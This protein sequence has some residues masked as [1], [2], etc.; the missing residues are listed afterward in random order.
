ML[1]GIGQGLD[2]L[3]NK[4]K[5]VGP[6]L[7]GAGGALAGL[8]AGLS[9]FGSKDQAAHQ[10]LQTAV[11]ATGKSYDDFA[12]PIEQAIKN[13]EKFGHTADETQ[14]ALQS[15]T[16]ATHDPQKAIDLLGTA[17][18]LAAAKHEDL[19]TAAGQLG[20]VYNGN[21][22]LLKEFGV[23][24]DTSKDK[25]TAAHDATAE[26]GKMLSGQASASADTF[27]GKLDGIKAH[28][29]DQVAI[30]GQK[31]GP[32][33][34]GIG[35][36]V[37]TLGSIWTVVG[38]LMG[39]MASIALGPIGLIVLAVIGL[40]A[41]GYVLYRNWD[42]IWSGIQT[43]IGAVWDW[44]TGHWPLLLDILL[45][46][47]GIAVNL[48]IDHWDAIKNAFAA[49]IDFIRDHWALIVGFLLGPIALAAG[50]IYTY[51]D[52]IKGGASAAVD[53]IKSLWSGLGS[54]ISTAMAGL[55][56]IIAAPFRVAWNIISGIVD[57]ITGALDHIKNAIG[58]VGGALS[59]IPGAGLVTGALSHLASGGIV[60]R[61][62]LALV[63]ERE[64]EAVI[65]LSRLGSMLAGGP[66][67]VIE[68]ANFSQELDVD[69]FM[70]R[71]A[72][73]AQTRAM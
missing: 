28:L 11:E 20:K 10:Q 37:M 30:F 48:I 41:I 27:M 21:A 44:I 5:G 26:L 2:S 57:Q 39:A 3:V 53:F 72:W 31:Y 69:L 36:A 40:I 22:K 55:E 58:D 50:L 71:A 43:A 25:T 42:T 45:G 17:S 65:P 6:A 35:I 47:I 23:H 18:D 70:R 61:P 13:Q 73:V 38:P 7:A 52:N 46:P 33:L 12:D 24:L 19:N 56:N 51:W 8:G 62:T 60:T 64:S 32:A 59:H 4:A 16:Q 1:D 9:A 54:A 67:V 66:S 15:L 29:E 14:N 49:V 34:Q 68:N 63:G